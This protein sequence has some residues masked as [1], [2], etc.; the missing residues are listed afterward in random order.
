[1]LKM[2]FFKLALT[3]S[4]ST[5]EGN[6][7]ERWNSPTMRSL[8]QYLCCGAFW[9]SVSEDLFATS[10]DACSVVDDDLSAPDDVLAPLSS[11]TVALW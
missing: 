1:M 8:T 2:P 10:D 9:T 11:S 7:K 4:W 5:R 6:E 3:A